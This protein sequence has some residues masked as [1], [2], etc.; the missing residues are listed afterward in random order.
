M[1]AMILGAGGFIGTNLSI[2]LI[3]E[4]I[5]VTLVDY[6]SQK[7]PLS[8][9]NSDYTKLHN[10][11]F[12][13]ESD[14]DTLVS[15]FDIIYHLISTTIPSNSNQSISQ[16]FDDNVITTI[17]FLDACV[18]QKVKRVVFISSGGTVYGLTGNLS[19]AEDF[20][21]NPINAYGLQKLTI[22]KLL[23]LYHYQFGLDYRVVRLSNPYGPY[24]NPLG[25][26]G[27]IT[28]FIY[29]TIN[30]LPL[31]IW[32]NGTVIRD[33]IYIDDAVN[34]IFNISG[35]LTKEKVYNVGSGIGI[36]ILDIINEIKVSLNLNMNLVFQEGR[37]VDVPI[38][39]LDIN[40]YVKEFGTGNMISMK[41]GIINTAK[42]L[43]ETEY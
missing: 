5:N 13:K 25:G 38:N 11:C 6:S 42:F 3:N 19:I 31:N 22:E 36:S 20:Q 12:N 41:Q 43:K 37:K 39:I 18:R 40:R 10:M 27:V 21:T 35:D 14:F 8:I 28:A 23:Y 34:A 33:Y 26:Q 30:G 29:N 15:G 2:K 17:K 4:H 9:K 1:K 32:G 16:E 7:I 24:Q